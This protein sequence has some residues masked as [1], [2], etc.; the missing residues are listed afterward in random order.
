MRRFAWERYGGC[1]LRSCFPEKKREKHPGGEGESMGKNWA[2]NMIL[3]PS[4]Q[5]DDAKAERLVRE[6]EFALR[7]QG[8]TDQM[9]LDY[10]AALAARLGRAPTKE[11]TIGYVY[12]KQ[13]LGNWP[14]ILIRAGLKPEIQNRRQNNRRRD[15][16]NQK[17]RDAYRRRGKREPTGSQ[18]KET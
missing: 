9:L 7:H 18:G 6:K 2:P 13:R 3:L 10:V 16:K 11:E 1:L 15:Q 17:M 8:D 5:G 14:E 12:L 4:E